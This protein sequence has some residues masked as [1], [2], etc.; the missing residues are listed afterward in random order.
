MTATKRHHTICISNVPGSLARNSRL[1]IMDSQDEKGTP[2]APNDSTSSQDAGYAEETPEAHALVCM[3]CGAPLVYRGSGRRPRY[4]SSSCR[5]R[6]WER[7]RAA[8]EGLIAKEIVELPARPARTTYT[9]A[10]V[11]AWLQDHP[12]RFAEVVAALPDT[13]ESV[14]QLDA[15]RRRLGN[16]DI[17]TPAEHRTEE[18][19]GTELTRLRAEHAHT[20]AECSRLRRENRMLRERLSRAVENTGATPAGSGHR[21][22]RSAAVTAGAPLPSRAPQ[23]PAGSPPAPPGY[24]TVTV[25]GRTFHVP[26]AWSRTQARTW[27]RAH[28]DNALD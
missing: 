26:Q 18:R 24:R 13:A 17:P 11:I 22:S 25:A 3:E 19:A 5:H 4:C 8:A 2:P 15:A 20:V 21:V 12:R 28:A 23:H 1:T 10:G 16:P 9:R 6:A 7:R 27:C 14:R